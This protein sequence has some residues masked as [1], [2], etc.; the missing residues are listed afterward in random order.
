MLNKGQDWSK[1]PKGIIRKWNKIFVP[2]DNET[3]FEVIWAHHD[4]PIAGHPGQYRTQELVG[5]EFW[6]PTMTK[7]I[8][9]YVEAC[10]VCQHTKIH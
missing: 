6:W 7:D 3:I 10:E 9:K 8:K 5:R 2:N 1:D 4:S